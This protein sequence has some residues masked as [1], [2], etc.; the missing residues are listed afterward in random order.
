MMDF[1]LAVST[2]DDLVKEQGTAFDGEAWKIVR[3]KARKR[4]VMSNKILMNEAQMNAGLTEPDR[5]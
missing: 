2:I 5:E 1:E 3:D 4:D